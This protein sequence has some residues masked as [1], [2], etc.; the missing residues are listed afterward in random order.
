METNEI[1]TFKLPVLPTDG[2]SIDI[3]GELAKFEAEQRKELGLEEG[4]EQMTITFEGWP[5]SC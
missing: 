5:P 2:T 3:D 1:K 4:K